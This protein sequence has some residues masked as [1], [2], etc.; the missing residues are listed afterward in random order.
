M[1]TISAYAAFWLSVTF[2]VVLLLFLAC[3]FEIGKLRDREEAWKQRE[4]VI[5]ERYR[6]RQRVIRELKECLRALEEKL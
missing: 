2:V 4:R 3:V 5:L 1:I 6:Q